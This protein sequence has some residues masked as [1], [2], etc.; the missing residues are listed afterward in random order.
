[1]T[2]PL[3]YGESKATARERAHELLETVGL[4]PAQYARSTRTSCPAVSGSASASHAP[5]R[6]TRRCC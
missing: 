5:W 2:V 4:E 3:L 6:P 1:M